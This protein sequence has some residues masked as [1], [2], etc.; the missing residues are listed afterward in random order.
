MA[1]HTTRSI[2]HPTE[3]E[4][5]HKRVT[6]DPSEGATP[7]VETQLTTSTNAL[8]VNWNLDNLDTKKTPKLEEMLTARTA[9]LAAS[10]NLD[11]QGDIH[12]RRD[13]SSPHRGAGSIRQPRTQ[14]DPL[15]ETQLTTSTNAL[16][17]NWNIDTLDPKKT[18][19]QKR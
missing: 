13:A 11:P 7:S 8:S 18:P 15:E 5:P 14:K 16:L 9:V 3:E 1:L 2:S 12:I 6:L 19:T 4:S 10:N 17:I